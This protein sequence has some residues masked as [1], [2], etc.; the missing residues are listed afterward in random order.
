M[1]KGYELPAVIEA[2]HV[3]IENWGDAGTKIIELIFNNP[4]KYVLRISGDKFLDSCS[5]CGGNWGGMFLTGIKRLAPD[6]YDAIPDDMGIYAW[7]CI[8]AVLTLMRVEF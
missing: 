5:A 8:T 4:E 1:F 6:I 3:L 7:N 2:S